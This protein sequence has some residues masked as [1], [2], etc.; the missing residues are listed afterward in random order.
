MR[1]NERIANMRLSFAMNTSQAVQKVAAVMG[2]DEYSTG[3]LGLM[4]WALFRYYARRLG[5]ECSLDS[6]GASNGKG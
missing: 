1:R 4:L 5:E 3:D 2:W 6:T